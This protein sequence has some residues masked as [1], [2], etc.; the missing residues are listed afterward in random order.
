MRVN[1]AGPL[2][3]R[4]SLLHLIIECIHDRAVAAI[5]DWRLFLSVEIEKLRSGRRYSERKSFTM[6][7]QV[8]TLY[9]C[10]DTVL[11]AI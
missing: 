9:T 11:R 3:R 2:F 8:G 6:I 7:D 4:A 1:C 10:A 5:E